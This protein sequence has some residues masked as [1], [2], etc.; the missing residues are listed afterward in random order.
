MKYSLIILIGV[1]V[2]CQSVDKVEKPKQLLSKDQMVNILTD[3]AILK[4]AGDVNQDRLNKYIKE[5]FQYIETK[6]S[7]DSLTLAKNIEYYNFEF[8]ENLEIYEQVEERINKRDAKID[9]MTNYLDSIDK[10]KDIQLK[11]MKQKANR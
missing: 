5:P 1:M 9:S 11:K 10:N 4:A 8:N 3:I 6:Y 7:I 2:A